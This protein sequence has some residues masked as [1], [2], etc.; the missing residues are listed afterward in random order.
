VTNKGLLIRERLR[1]VALQ[2]LLQQIV[3]LI[4]QAVH[5][6]MGAIPLQHGEFRVV[7]APGLF[8]AKAAAHLID[9]A[10]S[11]RQQAFHVVFRA[12]H[13]P[14]IAAFRQA[15]T[16]KARLERHQMNVGNCGLTH[17][18]RVDFQY[19]AIGEETTHFSNN[20]CAFN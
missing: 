14:E 8:I 20:G 11:G 16:D 9:R 3:N 15:R 5:I 4:H 10:T 13:Q 12:G 6:I 1:A 19:A 17:R 18:G 2:H 7:V